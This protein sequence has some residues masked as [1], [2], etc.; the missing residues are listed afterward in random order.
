MR[1]LRRTPALLLADLVTAAAVTLPVLW[2]YGWNRL[3]KPPLPPL[4]RIAPPDRRTSTRT[5]RP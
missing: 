3:R 1:R 2:S 4:G 5:G